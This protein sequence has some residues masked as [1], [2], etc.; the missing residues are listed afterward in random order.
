MADSVLKLKVDDKEYNASLKNAKTGIQALEASL[1]KAGKTFND[2]DKKVVEYVRAIGNMETQSK[3]ARGRIGE[4]STAFVELSQQYNKMTKDVQQS[5]VGKALSESMTTLR[6][7]TIEAKQE[8]AKLESQLREVNNTGMNLPDM[9]G[10]GGGGFLSGLGGK[11]GGA[12]QV[13][14][15]NMM[16]KAAGWAMSAVSEMQDLVAQSIE[17]SKAAQGIEIAYNRLNKPGLLDNLKEA[18]HGTVSELELMKAAV[19][20]NDFK[21]PL[22]DLGTYLAFAQQKAKD[23]GESVDYMVNSI[24]TGLGRQSKQIL[25]N[26]GI[27]ASEITAKMKDGGDMTKAVAEIIREKMAAAGDYVETAADRA[28]KAN[29]DL[30]NAMKRLGDTFSPLTESASSMWSSIKTGALDVLNNAVRPLIDALTEAG[31]I[32]SKYQ[33]QNSD[34]RVNRMVGTLGQVSEGKRQGIYNRQLQNFDTKIGSY[35]Q[36]LDDYKKWQ[37]DKTA[38]GAYDRMQAFQK[39]TGLSMFS[40]VKEQ[41]EVFKK[42]RAEYVMMSKDLLSPK[43]TGLDETVQTVDTLKKKLKDL[44]SDYRAA[45][46]AGDSGKAGDLLKQ[47]NQTKQDIKGLDPTA[48]TTSHTTTPAQRAAENIKAAEQEYSRA[49]E[50]AALEVQGGTITE[51]QQKQKQLQATEALWS[52]Y[53]KASDTVNGTNA[54]YKARQEQLGQ[55]IV[56][57][58]GEAKSLQEAQKQAEE[59]YRQVAAQT[60]KLAD[61]QEEDNH[62]ISGNDLKAFYAAD[63]KITAAGGQSAATGAD[64]SQVFT[65]TNADYKARQEQLGQEIVKLG[66]EAKSLQEAQKQAEEAYRQVAAQTKKLA[67]AQEEDNHA[68]SGNDLKAFYAADK[69]ITAAGGQS[70]ATGADMSQVFTGTTANIDAFIGNLKERI[71]QS[72]VGTDL[73]KNLTKQLADTA[74]LSN[75]LQ[76]AIKNG[77]DPAQIGLDPK[78]FWSKVFGENPGDYIKDE[79]W[80]GIVE[81]MNAYL[82]DKG[83]Q[84]GLDAN[85]GSVSS[86]SKQNPYLSKNED[87]KMEAKLTNVVSGIAGGINN[88]VSGIEQM[89]IEIPEGLKQGLSAI[90][91]V[92][93]ILS[94]IATTVLAIEAIAGADALIPFARGG[95]VHAANGFVPGNRYSADDINVAVSSGEL[96]LNRA[97]QGNLASQLS[98]GEGGGGMRIVGVLKGHDMALMLDRWGMTTG[99]GELLFGKNL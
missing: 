15:G 87:G 6:Q 66:G 71:S 98:G 65:G 38:V 16:T 59:A 61:A 99:R 22:E 67:D 78:E 32:R 88:M 42:Q 68:I 41:M 84:I 33:Q 95:I 75:L 89:G 30:E 73:Y 64:M 55:E 17:V 46:K 51:A 83:I 86:K 31:R 24:V 90:Q 79:T 4:M 23:T 21:L 60:K 57:L 94:G 29:A 93:S 20:F 56:K 70:A 91:G 5:D 11:M 1:Q 74:A 36:Y 26:L 34:Q 52:A 25:D 8:L 45:I 69:K 3:S 2:C 54:D 48:L 49:L 39:Q 35:Q 19:K 40:D 27:S 96:I 76:T 63:K 13:F 14:A 43:Q 58:G 62:A 72:E 50:K 44:Q 53:G 82:K 37:S 28:S 85:T 92:T 81:K 9:T 47:I 18:T 97:Q 80:Q 12:L 77:I 7:R 10:G